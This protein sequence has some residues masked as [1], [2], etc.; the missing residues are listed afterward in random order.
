MWEGWSQLSHWPGFEVLCEVTLHVSQTTPRRQRGSGWQLCA[1]SLPS[2]LQQ[3]PS[4]E[5]SGLGAAP[6]LLKIIP[7]DR[8]PG[9]GAGIHS[10]GTY[11]EMEAQ[12]TLAL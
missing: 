10:L 6:P 11:E 3:P 9:G 7:R 2:S 4:Q 12:E 8:G 1:D 5:L